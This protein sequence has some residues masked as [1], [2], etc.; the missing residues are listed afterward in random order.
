MTELTL[1]ISA[2]EIQELELE[3][4]SGSDELIFSVT[5]RV[6]GVDGGKIDKILRAQTTDPVSLTVETR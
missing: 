4:L 1:D 3:R 5:G 6:A 2:T